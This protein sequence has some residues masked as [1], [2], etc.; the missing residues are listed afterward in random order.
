MRLT[1]ILIVFLICS[2]PTSLPADESCTLSAQA[3]P[4]CTVLADAVKYDGKEIL[5]RG[6][7]R[8]VIHGAILAGTGCPKINVN[9]R[10]G[11]NWNGDKRA[12]AVIRS[13]TKKNQFRSVDVVS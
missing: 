9:L 8:M 12:L 5:V 6:L 1:V 11:P 10:G 7:Y 2:S 13:V 3:V 4:L